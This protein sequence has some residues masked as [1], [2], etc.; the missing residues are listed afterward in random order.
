VRK[1][2]AGNRVDLPEHF[3]T[4]SLKGSEALHA[5]WWKQLRELSADELRVLAFY[6]LTSIQALEA[7]RFELRSEIERRDELRTRRGKAAQLPVVQQFKAW[8][9]TE[10]ELVRDAKSRGA[11]TNFA[12]KVISRKGAPITDAKTVLRWCREWEAERERSASQSIPWFESDGTPNENVYS[13]VG[14]A[15]DPIPSGDN[16]DPNIPPKYWQIRRF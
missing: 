11:L 6:A 1:S 7:Q 12:R 13:Q 2:D 8:V 3:L 14:L 5:G 4:N 15:P 16:G 9:K 10:W